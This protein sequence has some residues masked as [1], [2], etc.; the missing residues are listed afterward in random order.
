MGSG[1]KTVSTGTSASHSVATPTHTCTSVRA[2]LVWLRQSVLRS[3]S[4]HSLSRS[5]PS[6]L[7]VPSREHVLNELLLKHNEN[8][9]DTNCEKEEE[10]EEWE[11]LYYIN[12]DPHIHPTIYKYRHLARFWYKR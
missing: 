7:A 1:L 6:P 4:P 10:E 11:P 8:L 2:V 9:E 12:G 5:L 3:L